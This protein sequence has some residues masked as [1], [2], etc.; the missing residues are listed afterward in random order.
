[1][2]FGGWLLTLLVATAAGF[3]A[4]EWGFMS[5]PKRPGRVIIA[6][7][8]AVLIAIAF[9][10]PDRWGGAWLAL[11]IGVLVAAAVARGFGERKSDA[12]FGPSTSARPVCWCSG[13]GRGRRAQPGCWRFS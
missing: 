13:C 4:R 8:A 7:M 9:T 5:A 3:L 6:V 2:W 10:V 1:V 11:G 12:A